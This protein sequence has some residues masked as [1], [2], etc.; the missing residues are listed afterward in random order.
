MPSE[1]I[2][3]LV[4][5]FAMFLQSLAGFGS[6]LISMPILVQALGL[7]VAAPLFALIAFVAELIMI[8]RHRRAFQIQSVWRLMAASIVSIPIGIFGANLLPEALMLRLLG[9]LVLG[10]A[11]YALFAPQLPRLKDKRWAYGF[12]FTAGL[13]SGAY[14][15]G[16]PPYVIYASVQGWEPGEFKINLQSVFIVSTMTIII[17]HT[18]DHKMTPDVIRLF[19]LAVPAVIVGMF[20]GFLLERFISPLVF[21]RGILMLL[22]VLGLTLVF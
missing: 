8:L 2:V 17:G 11:L 22:V 9:V 6:A 5:L 19:I 1:L 15:T 20:T 13:L 7:R 4:I 3:V 16:G 21:R 18:L 14:N 10:Y 12:G